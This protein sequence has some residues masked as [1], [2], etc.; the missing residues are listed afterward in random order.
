MSFM[1]ETPV[2]ASNIL[3]EA[4]NDMLNGKL[5]LGQRVAVLVASG[6]Q[7]YDIV[8]IQKLFIKAGATLRMVSPEHS[9]INTWQVKNGRGGWGHNFAADKSLADALSVD[10]DALI[11]PAGAY[12]VQ[13]L[14]LTAH[15]NRFIKGFLN[16][17][18]PIFLMDEACSLLDDQSHDAVLCNNPQ[19][20]TESCVRMITKLAGL[21][22]HNAQQRVA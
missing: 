2:F 8:T 9:L 1:P 3:D 15:T 18:K 16:L 11:V 6:V 22:D 20:R 5:L 4:V 13:K 19:M 12:H 14:K 10:Y 17:N 21:D 7:E